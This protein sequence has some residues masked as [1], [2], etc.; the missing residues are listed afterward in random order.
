MRK[1]FAF[2]VTGLLLGAVLPT[3]TAAAETVPI[4]FG[5]FWVQSGIFKSFGNNSKA[6][7]QAFV[8][9]LESRGGV[10]LKNG[11]TGKIETTFYD[12][13]CN[14]EQALAVVRKMATQDKLLLAVGPSCSSAL[15]PVFGI[16]QKKLDDPSDTGLQ[17]MVFSDTS[18]K[19]GLGKISPWGFRA[20]P[21]ESA[22]YLDVMKHLKAIGVKSIAFG[23]EDD[24]A[25][26][27]ATYKVM[28]KHA[29][30]NG[31]EVLTDQ[32]WH[33]T[34]TE[35]STQARKIRAAKADAV[36]LSAHPFT[37]CGFLRESKRQK[38]KA[39]VF[40][41]LTSSSS[42]ETLQGC[43]KEAKG[44]IIPTAFA[45]VNDEARRIAALVAKHGG[46]MDIHSA[47]VWEVMSVL[48]SALENTDLGL[49]SDTLLADRRKI[50]DYVAAVG[51]WEGL[52]GTIT[53]KNKPEAHD[54][55]VSKPWLLAQA[56][57]P[58]WGIYWRP[59]MLGGTG[60]LK[61]AE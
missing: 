33:N 12:S 2:L 42:M 56:D 35:F 36:V 15:E 55:D 5:G 10:K 39:D 57:G 11:R 37:T 43:P 1:L 24:F 52:L 16:M 49:T 29:L 3:S 25:H 53:S 46:S 13:A 17:F 22:M 51:K 61:G 19:P 47:A 14:A 59:K 48:V 58:T 9:D 21:D 44:L 28:R 30:A 34:D 40:I 18:A 41:G 38:I 60:P 4:R 27:T 45:P 6:V 23:F 50:R 54:G 32:G 20:S 7:Y 26:S 31:L 8:E